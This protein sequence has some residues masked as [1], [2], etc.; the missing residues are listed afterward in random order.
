MADV[1]ILL[2]DPGHRLPRGSRGGSQGLSPH[3]PGRVSAHRTGGDVTAGLQFRVPGVAVNH[4][5]LEVK[6]GGEA[7][8]EDEFG[9]LRTQAPPLYQAGPNQ[10]SGP[11]PP[12]GPVW[13]SDS[14]L[15]VRGSQSV[16][17]Q[18]PILPKVQA[19]HVRSE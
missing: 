5:P 8:S 15:N 6:L 17:Y 19:P 1:L 7:R 9:G 4:D 18:H 2:P 16:I 14:E 10:G 12:W 13:W 3:P 11:L